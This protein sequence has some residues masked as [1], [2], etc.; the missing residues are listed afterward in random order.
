M[1]SVCG[2]RFG[3]PSALLLCS[4]SSF[5][6]P[7]IRVSWC[8]PS[9]GLLL[10][11]CR[12]H[13]ALACTFGGGCT[14]TAPPLSQV[15]MAVRCGLQWLEHESARA[16]QRAGAVEKRV[17][18]S[19]QREREMWLLEESYSRRTLHATQQQQWGLLLQH[20]ESVLAVLVARQ[21]LQSEEQCMR[22]LKEAE[23]AEGRTEVLRRHAAQHKTLSLL[24]Q[25]V[26]QGGRLVQP[27]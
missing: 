19:S 8:P 16:I 17:I 18:E 27:L 21:S 15:E 24:Y 22:R 20:E 9:W 1:N 3:P 5:G 23:E 25:Q 2:K 6:V 4:W 26:S 11:G 7:L 14:Y 13:W 10:L 12:L